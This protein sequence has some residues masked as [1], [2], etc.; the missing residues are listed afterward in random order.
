MRYLIS[1]YEKRTKSLMLKDVDYWLFIPSS[2]SFT[3]ITL[4]VQYLEKKSG[5]S[6][7]FV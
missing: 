6:V 7:L 4:F 1:K 5:F 2:T 3:F